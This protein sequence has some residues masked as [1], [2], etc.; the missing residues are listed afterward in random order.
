LKRGGAGRSFAGMDNPA[1]LGPATEAAIQDLIAEG[2]ASRDDVLR[3]GVA[4]LRPIE[5]PL[6]PETKAWLE[7]RIAEADADPDGGMLAED[8]FRELRQRY[9]H[10]S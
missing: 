6:D 9:E 10:W 2:Y 7:K 1:D 3:A 8:F 5:E 4:A